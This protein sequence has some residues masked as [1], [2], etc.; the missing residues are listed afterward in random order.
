MASRNG[1][2]HQADSLEEAA[3][4]YRPQLPVGTVGIL[5]W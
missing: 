2:R 5:G 3:A 1:N 4:L